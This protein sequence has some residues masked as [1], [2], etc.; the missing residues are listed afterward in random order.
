MRR[1]VLRLAS[2][3]AREGLFLYSAAMSS[4]RTPAAP[5]SVTAQCETDEGAAGQPESSHAVVPDALG[6]DYVEPRNAK[7]A[8]F[9][10]LRSAVIDDLRSDGLDDPVPA[11]DGNLFGASMDERVS[12]RTQRRMAR[13]LELGEPTADFVTPAGTSL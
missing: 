3:A 9:A 11:V 5:S 7:R 12:R 6:V 13:M 4:V 1:R 10:D 8:E 2:S